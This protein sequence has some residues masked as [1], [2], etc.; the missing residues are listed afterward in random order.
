MPA[1]GQEAGCLPDSRLSGGDGFSNLAPR[2]RN[3][4]RQRQEGHWSTGQCLQGRA[5]GAGT[6]LTLSAGGNGTNVV[7]EEVA[8]QIMSA[9]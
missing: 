8:A 2:S 7:T 5:G 6:A 3:S 1:S 9:W 4:S